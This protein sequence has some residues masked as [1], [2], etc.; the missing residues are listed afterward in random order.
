MKDADLFSEGSIYYY[1]N[2]TNSKKDYKNDDLNHDFLVS[3]PVFVLPSNHTPFDLFSVNVLS[4]TSSMHRA[5]IPININGN[6]K[7]KILPYAIYSVHKEYLT[8]YMGRVSDEM[9]HEVLQAVDYHMKR[10]D[11]IPKYLQ[12]YE[13]DQKRLEELAQKLTL[14][15]KILHSFLQNRVSYKEGYYCS[16]EELY[17]AY[18]RIVKDSSYERLVDFSRGMN[19]II[20]DFQLPIEYQS[21][22]NERVYY[23][24]SLEG[25]VH[26]IDTGKYDEG[27][28]RNKREV[29][30]PSKYTSQTN[31]SLENDAL[32]LTISERSAELYR[33]LDTIQKIG[34]YKKSIGEMET[35]QSK[36]Y[37]LSSK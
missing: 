22:R 30:L 3:R 28:K 27:K 21:N 16:Q 1:E 11:E 33:R 6:K 29:D 37:Q 13:H 9:I 23:G 8:T 14:K 17:K 18:Q 5:G 34:N 24:I 7:G 31:I 20:R 32:I 15:E 10:T 19:K 12:E 25:N 2:T 26:R 4:I 36:I 35:S